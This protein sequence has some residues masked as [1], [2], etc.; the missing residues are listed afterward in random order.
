MAWKGGRESLRTST[1][2]AER[3]GFTLLELVVT[4]AVIA[5]GATLVLP[6]LGD[7]RGLALAAAAR[8]LADT[9]AYGRDRAILGGRPMRLVLDLDRGRWELGTPGRDPETVLP[10]ATPTGRG[11]RTGWGPAGARSSAWPPSSRRPAGPG[12][13]SASPSSRRPTGR[14]RGGR[15]A[16]RRG[17]AV[18]SPARRRRVTRASSRIGSSRIEIGR[19]S[20]RSS[21]ARRRFPCPPPRR[22]ASPSSPGCAR[23]ACAA[24]T[25]A[26]GTR[27]GRR[28]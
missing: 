7:A 26:A 13:E 17:R 6:R 24:S 20:E 4:L 5:L 8:R 10:D 28:R 18:P 14:R 27:A 16:F 12:R 1:A 23:S 3:R 15:S 22:R 19:T 21:G 9:V 25:A 11:G 2:G